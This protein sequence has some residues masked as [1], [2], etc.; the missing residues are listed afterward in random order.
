MVHKPDPA[1]EKIKARKERKTAGKNARL[2][3]ARA[4]GHSHIDRHL[5]AVT[6]IR[7]QDLAAAARVV[8]EIKGDRLQ[9][10]S[11]DEEC[12]DCR[13]KQRATA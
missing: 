3:A 8:L 12:D 7:T 10:T 1:A 6:A 2:A 5:A 9:A 11:I 4:R 13:Q